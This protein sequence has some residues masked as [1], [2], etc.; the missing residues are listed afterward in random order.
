MRIDKNNYEQYL[1]DYLDGKLTPLE[2]SQVLLFL[3]LHPAIKAEF[4][5]I[6]KISIKEQEPVTFDTS[7][8]KKPGYAEVKGDYEN[9]LVAEVEGDLTVEEQIL[10]KQAKRL[11]PE[12][13][14]ASALFA[15]TLLT[16]EHIIF[17]N[18]KSLKKR[19]VVPLY[20]QTWIRVA[21]ILLIVALGGVLWLGTH[22][23]TGNAPDQTAMTTGTPQAERQGG[24]GN[25]TPGVGDREHGTATIE[26]NKPSSDETHEL[27]MIDNSPGKSIV[28][29]QQTQR[30]MIEHKSS[31]FTSGA[32]AFT[33][34]GLPYVNS[35]LQYPV[36][37]T[38][39]DTEKFV[40]IKQLALQE[41]ERKKE[42]L[43][44]RDNEGKTL[45]LLQAINKATGDNVK[46]DTNEAGRIKRF[47]IA[48]LGFEWSHSK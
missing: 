13:E 21:A 4:E 7:S 41:I 18:K 42:Y 19:I 10:L 43:L 38:Q 33:A 15:S 23:N 9:M 6:E 30:E 14:K 17:E 29:A 11:Y 12:L 20:R 44:G 34:P 48:G 31:I 22:N 36:S 45:T 35:Y 24:R 40:D 28:K 46:V 37:A 27:L 5:G 25:T 3:E 47:E 8:L 16:P 39:P 32:T 1:V 2:V 26:K